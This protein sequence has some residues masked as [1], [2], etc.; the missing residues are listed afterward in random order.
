M[1]SVAIRI[2]AL[3][4]LGAVYL[5][6]WCP[7]YASTGGCH[8]SCTATWRA[9]RKIAIANWVAC[10]TGCTGLSSQEKAACS[11]QCFQDKNAALVKAK[12]DLH[13]CFRVCGSQEETPCSGQCLQDKNAALVKAKED[14]HQ[15]FRVCQG[16]TGSCHQS[17]TAAWRQER[18]T[19]IDNWV[20]CKT[21]CT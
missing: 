20:A 11:A 7:A 14:L 5:G 12:E 17:C 6:A 8:Q 9:E 10:K 18:K 3:S 19:A 15:C 13:Q 4:L 16:T 21:G 2:L 1:N